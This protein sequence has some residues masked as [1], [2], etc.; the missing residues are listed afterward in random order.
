MNCKESTEGRGGKVKAQREDEQ[1]SKDK[2]G[3][4]QLKGQSSRLNGRSEKARKLKAKR[5]KKGLRSFAQRSVW[6]Q[7]AGKSGS[8]EKDVSRRGAPVES[9]LG[10]FPEACFVLE[11]SIRF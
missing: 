10:P 8:E 2:A 11:W 1:S 6:A 9:L 7:A 5:S 3:R 4:K